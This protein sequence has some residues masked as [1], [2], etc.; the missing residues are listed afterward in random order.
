MSSPRCERLAG[1]GR[2]EP[3]ACAGNLFGRS[4][5]CLAR[6]HLPGW[7]R[8]TAPGAAAATASL[9]VANLCPGPTATSCTVAPAP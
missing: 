3:L 7:T 2:A 9:M 1:T 6:P 8:I 4:M 5:L